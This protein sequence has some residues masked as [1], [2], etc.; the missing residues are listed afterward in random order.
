[1]DIQLSNPPQPKWTNPECLKSVIIT[2]NDVSHHTSSINL[3]IW[4]VLRGNLYMVI[5]RSPEDQMVSPWASYVWQM[6]IVL[7]STVFILYLFPIT[8]LYLFCIF[9]RR[10]GLAASRYLWQGKAWTSL[11]LW[12]RFSHRAGKGEQLHLPPSNYITAVTHGR[13]RTT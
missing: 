9:H 4:L 5:K 11:A 13:R 6:E 8:Y 2:G 1:M 3:N 10:F 7:W 12:N